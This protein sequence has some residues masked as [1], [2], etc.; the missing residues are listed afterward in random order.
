ML[1][2]AGLGM[3]FLP[4]TPPPPAP[5]HTPPAVLLDPQMPFHLLPGRASCCHRRPPASSL[6][7]ITSWKPEASRDQ[8]S[9]PKALGEGGEIRQALKLDELLRNVFFLIKSVALLLCRV[10][11]KTIA[12]PE[13][14][15]ESSAALP[16]AREG[17]EESQEME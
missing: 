2:C 3:R 13:W 15:V 9:L 16:K 12:L 6:A 4:T 17:R 5:P 7:C 8:G 1:L 11:L 10:S 14:Q